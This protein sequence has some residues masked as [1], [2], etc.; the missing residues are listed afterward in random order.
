MALPTMIAAFTGI[1][2][3]LDASAFAQD[4]RQPEQ[5]ESTQ[6]AC[7]TMVPPNATEASV[8]GKAK[9]S[10][11]QAQRVAEAAVPGMLLRSGLD[12]ENGCLV[13]SI[14]IR[15][16][17]SKIHEVKVDAGSSGILHQDISTE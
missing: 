2:L 5:V 7:S 8:K 4:T 1:A 14:E 6:Y 10:L 9:I 15:T 16:G 13:Y 11:V 3:A 17:D 12:N